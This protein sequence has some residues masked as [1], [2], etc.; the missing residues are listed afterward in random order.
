M[1]PA[2]ELRLLQ[3]VITLA[4]ELSF[5]D[6]AK[7]LYLAQPALSRHIKEV[8]NLLGVKL[9]D[10]N[11]RGVH[12]TP[13][14]LA[15]V[16]E[17]RAALIHSQRAEHLAKAIARQDGSSMIVGFSPHYNFHILG[18]IKKRSLARF[19]AK[20]ITFVSS[21]TNEQ[22]RY[23]L[24]GQW[25]AGLCFFPIEEADLERRVLLEE[26]VNVVIARDHKLA[27]RKSG[28]VR[29][30]ELTNE[31]VILF[32]RRIHPGFS[33]ELEQF[34]NSIGFSPKSTQDVSTIA[35]ALALVGEAAGIAFVKASLRSMLPENVKMLDLHEDERLTVKMGIQWRRT[36]HPQGVNDFLKLLPSQNLSI[37]QSG[38][39]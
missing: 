24:D 5:T 9:F 17:A 38:R 3:C 21:F 33:R 37:G 15:F 27:K 7:K 4:E 32:S 2:I 8:E 39:L 10:R 29:H 13:S 36:G 28:K 12:L 14:G 34:W 22:I 16:G 18:L 6:A 30:E 19:G 25:A 11:T 23:I 1:R 31:P 26:C 35:E 20:G